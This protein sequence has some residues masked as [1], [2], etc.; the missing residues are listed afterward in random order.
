MSSGLRPYIKK[1]I[2]TLILIFRYTTTQQ[3]PVCRHNAIYAAITWSDLKKRFVGIAVGNTN[4]GTKHAQ[5]FTLNSKGKPVWL[6]IING[7]VIIGQQHNFCPYEFMT[8]NDFQKKYV[9]TVNFTQQQ[10]DKLVKENN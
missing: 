6:Q 9:K 10:L 5:A 2:T 3:Q 7:R 1:L 8:V 4:S